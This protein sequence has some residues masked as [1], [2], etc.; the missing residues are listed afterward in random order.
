MNNHIY[1]V[2]ELLNLI[3]H[4]GFLPFFKNRIPGFSAHRNCGLQQM[5]RDHGSGKVR[6]PG[7]ADVYMVNFLTGKPDL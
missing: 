6:R 2:E 4:F 7:A 5:Q 3:E 1:N